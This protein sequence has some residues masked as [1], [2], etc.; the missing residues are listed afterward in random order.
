VLL[1]IFRKADTYIY[2]LT[3]KACNFH[4]YYLRNENHYVLLLLHINTSRACEK[5]YVGCKAEKTAI[6]GKSE[7]LHSQTLRDQSIRK[8]SN[9]NL[10]YET[11]ASVQDHAL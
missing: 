6:Y 10:C 1:L 9:I 8:K 2:I 5:P 11:N 7:V 3:L 4:P